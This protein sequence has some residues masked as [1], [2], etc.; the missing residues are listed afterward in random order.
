[1]K[2]LARIVSSSCSTTKTLLPKSLIFCNV[3]INLSLS[4]WCNPIDGSSKT[5]NT[6]VNLEPICV[7]KR[8]RCAS[9]PERPPAFLDKVK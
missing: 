2:S 7:A 1:M 4:R 5:Y 9:P 8:I 3:A 6:P